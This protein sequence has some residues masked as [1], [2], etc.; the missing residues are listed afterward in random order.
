MP[1]SAHSKRRSHAWALGHRAH[2]AAEGLKRGGARRTRV[3]TLEHES[4]RVE[5]ES[6]VR[7]R[8]A[9]AEGKDRSGRDAR[10][11]REVTGGEGR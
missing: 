5:I 9:G 7:T 8:K 11:L 10:R 2:L 3:N 4:N 1:L 6:R